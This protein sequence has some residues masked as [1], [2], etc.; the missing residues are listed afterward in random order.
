MHA[1]S[2]TMDIFQHLANHDRGVQRSRGTNAR[3]HASPAAV[4][5]RHQS[6]GSDAAVAALA[7]GR[8]CQARVDEGR[9]QT[10]EGDLLALRHRAGDGQSADG[11]CPQRYRLATKPATASNE[12]VASVFGRSRQ[13][14]VK[15]VLNRCRR[16][17]ETSP[18]WTHRPNSRQIVAML[19]RATSRKGRSAFEGIQDLGAKPLDIDSV[20]RSKG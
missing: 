16:M 1:D 5:C 18:T 3:T 4:G 10:V 6:H 8:G 12:M 2:C 20:A 11:V 14:P 17:C 9:A 19:A 15:R 7:G 13:I